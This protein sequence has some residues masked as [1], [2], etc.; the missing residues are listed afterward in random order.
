[1]PVIG[2]HDFFCHD[3]FGRSKEKAPRMHIIR[4][5]ADIRRGLDALAAADPRLA[6]VIAACDGTV[7]LRLQPAGYAGIAHVVVS[8]MVSRASANAIWGRMVSALGEVSADTYLAADPSVIAGF[9]LS[10]AKETTLRRIAAAVADAAL[11]LDAVPK[12]PAGEAM[13][14]LTSVKGIGPWTAEIY[15]M[16]CGGHPDIFPVGDVALRAAA[17]DLFFKGERPDEKATRAVATAWAPWRSV[18][19]RLLWADYARRRQREAL[20]VT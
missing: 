9:G 11:D 1:L 18:A 2:L 3:C 20:P 7:P 6:P 8:Q 15:L 12:L 14:Q 5:E 10:R 16:F 17:G 19:A 13:A 4:S